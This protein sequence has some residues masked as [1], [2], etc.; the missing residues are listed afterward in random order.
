MSVSQNN[1]IDF[2]YIFKN[3]N[4]DHV[5]TLEYLVQANCEIE[6]QEVQLQ[7]CDSTGLSISY[8]TD[9]A[10]ENR[11]LRM[12]FPYEA[13]S[14]KEFYEELDKFR[15]DAMTKL[16]I[17]ISNSKEQ[18]DD[19]E[20]PPIPLML[21]VIVG[22]GF[23]ICFTF[24]FFLTPE[25]NVIRDNVGDELMFRMLKYI[26]GSNTIVAAI[27]LLVSYLRGNYTLG[28]T[29]KWMVSSFLFGM[30]SLAV[31]VPSRRLIML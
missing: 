18:I 9:A 30:I 16:K 19:F 7:S 20:L 17:K 23:L 3:I 15:K 8:K 11:L 26:F 29:C 25:M 28:C 5:K 24:R 27:S 22:V 1:D 12:D 4:K 6:C 13:T 2:E 10:T 21:L 14:I 31:Q